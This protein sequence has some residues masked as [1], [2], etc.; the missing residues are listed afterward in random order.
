MNEKTLE[1]KRILLGVTGSIAAYKSAELIRQL[2][3]E[4]ADV[5]VIMTA[6]ATA[7]ITPM[8]LQTLSGH[9]VF[10]SILDVESEA[11]MSHIALARFA[12]I[13]LIAPA[14]A[15]V[16][17]K[18]AAGFADDLL[19]TVC[20]ATTAPIVIAPAMNVMM[21]ENTITQENVKKLQ[22]RKIKM[23]GPD[24]GI[25]ACGE[26]GEG[27]MLEPEKIIEEI[28]KFF[29]KSSHLTGKN[30][31][32]TAGPTREAVDPVRYLSNHSSGKM[33]YAI[34]EAAL[35]AG[36]NVTL[37]SGPTHLAIASTIKKIDVIT[38]KEM[39]DAVLSQIKNCDI[40]ISTA[41]VSDYRPEKISKNKIKKNQAALPLTL[42]KNPDILATV[43]SL[44]T[45]PFLVGFAAETE[46][47]LENATKKLKEK[48]LNMI[49]A[50]L[51]GEG[52][53]FGQDENKIIIIRAQEKKIKKLSGN[54]KKLAEALV[55]LL[56]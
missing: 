17:A 27:R 38:A 24:S 5:R 29:R 43:A 14:T 33:G 30:V 7:F 32:I 54:K 47:L 6:E 53:G 44:P 52:K 50:N 56:V 18:L 8:T 35:H 45:P 1:N 39:L 28:K 31:V 2:K 12:D 21:W 15:H 22:E 42:I 20:L 46:N 51:V 19:T 3:E 34:A 4:G 25:Q 55:D 23:W 9:R 11:K 41:A 26:M 40:F 16:I 10:Q 37:I 48:K 13:I 49:V 36:A